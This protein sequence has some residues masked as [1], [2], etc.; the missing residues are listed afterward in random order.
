MTQRRIPAP[1][2]ISLAIFALV[3]ACFAYLFIIAPK[4]IDDFW[5]ANS[6]VGIGMWNTVLEHWTT[7]T[8]RLG[9]TLGN[10]TIMLPHWLPAIF[11]SIMFVLGYFLMC[12]V[13]GIERDEPGRLCFVTFFMVFGLPWGDNIFTHMFAFNYVW[14]MPVVMAALWLW[15][16]RPEAPAWLMGVAGLV[17]GLWHEVFA[18]YLISGMLVVLIIHRRMSSRNRWIMIAGLAAALVFELLS[19]AFMSRAGRELSE[20]RYG[21]YYLPYAWF[22][23]FYCGAWLLCMARKKWRSAALLPLPLLA[24]LPCLG[25]CIILTLVPN[26]RAVFMCNFIAVAALTQLVFNIIKPTRAWHAICAVMIAL[27]FAHLAALVT[28]MTRT[29]RVWDRVVE[30]TTRA[31][32]RIDNPGKTVLTVFAP[33]EYCDERPVYPHLGRAISTIFEC[34]GVTKKQFFHYMGFNRWYFMPSGVYKFNP[35]KHRRIASN[36]ECYEAQGGLVCYDVDALQGVWCVDLT[37]TRGARR[38]P[39]YFDQQPLTDIS[40]RPCIYVR[41]KR[42]LPRRWLGPLTYVEFYPPGEYFVPGR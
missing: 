40:G 36:L 26:I 24:V 9:N 42:N 22:S 23:I 41:I 15:L 34:D 6:V 20:F 10:L 5:Y 13:A 32:E 19:P 8:I 16:K 31:Y 18:V 17:A 37:F 4:A 1:K 2:A 33:F 7:D 35:A 28:E 30:A 21:Q 38:K 3:S 39:L 12:A 14:G 29:V 11:T 27:V 25:G